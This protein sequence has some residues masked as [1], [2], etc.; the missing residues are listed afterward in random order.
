MAHM[1]YIRVPAPVSIEGQVVYSLGMLVTFLVDNES[2][3]QRPASAARAG[4]RIL[5]ALD[6][7]KNDVLELRDEDWAMLHDVA[8]NPD[9]GYANLVATTH[10][11]DGK[12]TSSQLKV[13]TR[14]FLPLINAIDLATNCDPCMGTSTAE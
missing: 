3:F 11:V 8:E 12:P 2:R 13:S 4:M 10:D 6:A 9:C 1:K 14:L 5:V 7:I